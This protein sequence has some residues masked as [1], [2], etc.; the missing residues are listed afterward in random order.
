M[1]RDHAAL[2]GYAHE[3]ITRAKNSVTDSDDVLGALLNARPNGRPLSERALRSHVLGMLFAGNET[4][5]AALGWALVHGARH[6]AEWAKVRT[7]ASFGP[8]F[9]DETMRLSPAVWGFA[10]SSSGGGGAGLACGDVATKVKR[11]EVVTIYLRGMN[12]DAA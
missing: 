7:D 12:R 8:A 5:A 2:D 11:S 3:I 4:T 1:R 6:P 10:R 9:I